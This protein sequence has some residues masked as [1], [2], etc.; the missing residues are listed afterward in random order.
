MV[1]RYHSRLVRDWIGRLLWDLGWLLVVQD[2]I[3]LAALLM[4][5]SLLTLL[6]GRLA[7]LNSWSLAVLAGAASL[8]MSTGG[9]RTLVSDVCSSMSESCLCFTVF[10]LFRDE[11]QASTARKAP[12]NT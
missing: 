4:I 8:V 1:I 3:D 12:D 9:L 5:Q 2:A 11:L 6:S 10:T 7:R